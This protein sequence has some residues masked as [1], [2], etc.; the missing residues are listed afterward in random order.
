MPAAQQQ[1]EFA[2]YE[3]EDAVYHR[4][5]ERLESELQFGLPVKC[6]E[7][8]FLANFDFGMCEVVVIVGQ[9]GL[10]ANAAKYVGDLPIVAVNPD[11]QRIDGVLLPFRVEQARTMVRR[12]LDGK[13]RSRDVTLAEVNLNDG[14]RMLAFNDFFIGAASH[15]SARYTLEAARQS[16]P[17]SSSGILISTGAGSTGWMSLGLQHGLAALG[18]FWAKSFRPHRRSPGKTAG[19]CGACASRSSASARKRDSLPAG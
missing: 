3:R 1:A 4:V 2:E 12:V 14:Q 11:P 10:V 6:V 5:V 15:V 9:D 18:R 16:E 7:R 19:W 13:A 8:S 17:Q